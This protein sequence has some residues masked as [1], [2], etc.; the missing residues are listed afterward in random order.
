MKN[1][2]AEKGSLQVYGN[3]YGTKRQPD[4]S[5]KDDT[6]KQFVKFFEKTEWMFNM[7]GLLRQMRFYGNDGV[8]CIIL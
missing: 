7:T 8:N 5:P 6:A 3:H 4:S 1:V 2:I